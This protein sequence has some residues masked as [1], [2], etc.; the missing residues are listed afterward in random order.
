[1]LPQF[2]VM[3]R[4]RI[5]QML[6]AFLAYAVAVE[7]CLTQFRFHSLPPMSHRTGRKIALSIVVRK[8]RWNA[9]ATNA[10]VSAGDSVLF[11]AHESDDL[12][13]IRESDS[14]EPVQNG[15]RQ[16][17]NVGSDIRQRPPRAFRLLKIEGCFHFDRSR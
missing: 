8:Q 4:Y 14:R 9:D 5:V 2:A 7:Y 12:T 3:D 15:T 11:V 13:V 16:F 10:N 6:A 17:V 1:V